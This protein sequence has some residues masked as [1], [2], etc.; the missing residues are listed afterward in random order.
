MSSSRGEEEIPSP[1]KYSAETPSATSIGMIEIL[2]VMTEPLPFTMLSPLGLELTSLL[3]PQ[4]KNV[5][6]TAEAEVI[7]EP[8]APGGGNTQK[9]RQMMNVTRAVLDTLPPAVQEKIVSTVGD[10]GPH[11]AE[12]SSGPLGTTL[13]EIDRLIANVALGKILRGQLLLRLRR[14]RRK[15]LKKASSKDKSFDL[16]HLGGQQLSEEDISELKEFAMSGSYRPGSVLFGGVDEE[17]LGCIRDRAR[18]KIVSTLLKIIRFLKLEKDIS[19][20]RRQH[21]TCNLFYSN[22]KV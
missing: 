9:K 3:Q 10:E 18:V 22:F 2:E 16:R 7:K 1:P 15:E 11:Q 21:I 5:E 6:R 13:S 8:S 19:G 4:K 17:I 20:Y 12:N 14:Q